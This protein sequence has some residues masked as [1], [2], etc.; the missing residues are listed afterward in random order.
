ME[1]KA[2][3]SGLYVTQK[4]LNYLRQVAKKERMSVA[5][6]CTRS[7]LKAAEKIMPFNE[8]SQEV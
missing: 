4:E 8:K 6:F 2:V 5:A 1:K 3:A 7:A